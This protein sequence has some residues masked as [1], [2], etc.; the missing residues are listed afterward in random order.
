MIRKLGFSLVLVT[1][2]IVVA[3]GRQVTPN[4]PGLGA[5][6]ANPG[7]MVLK[8]DVA[9]P[10]NF[11]SYQYWVIF[12]TTGNGKSPLTNPQQNNWAAFS[13]GIE[14][15]GNGGSTYA[16]AVQFLKNANPVIP[17]YPQPLRGLTPQQFTYVANSD[18]ANTEFTVTFKRSIFAPINTPTP[19]PTPT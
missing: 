7:Y 19:G 17:P 15:G 16:T 6:G 5:G 3:C 11:S 4:P 9:A 1:A 13:D 8:F 10:F 2:F 14:V 12:N 18:G